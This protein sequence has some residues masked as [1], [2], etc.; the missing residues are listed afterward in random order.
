MIGIYVRL[1]RE[2][3]KIG[4]SESIDN[5]INFLK[6]YVKKQ[7]WTIYKI[8]IDDGY[9]GTNFDR[10]GFKNLI[11]DIE[12]NKIDTVITKD[13]S[14]LG[15]DYIDTGYYI[16]KY[17][18]MKKIRY[19]AVNDGI[20][21]ID[22]MN[23]N[24]DITPF[25]A[26]INDMYAKDISKKVKTALLTKA[27]NGENI[28]SFVP[29]GYKKTENNKIVIDERV[30]E[31]V[32]TIFKLYLAGKNKKEICKYLDM[33]PII[34][35]ARYKMQY[36][37]YK[38]PN[39][40][41]EGWSKTTITNILKDRTYTGDLVQHKYSSV[42]YKIK[43]VVKL[44][45]NQF[46]VIKDNHEPII[47]REEYEK[48]QQMLKDKANECKRREQNIHILTGICFCAKCGERITYTKNHGD[49]YKI[50]CSNYKKNGA[51]ACE[52]I[53]L[54]EEMV[55]SIIKNKLIENIA[56]RGLELIEVKKDDKDKII[57]LQKE[58]ERNK[59][60]I[61]QVYDD[62]KEMLISD[63]VSKELLKKYMEENNIKLEKLSKLQINEN[64][65]VDVIK[66]I[67]EAN[68]EE[69]RSLILLMISKITISKKTITIYYNYS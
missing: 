39:K 46:I 19:I 16:E 33:K 62:R 18:P 35:P 1:S 13:L 20:D 38:N 24:N 49:S 4:T 10:P 65:K 68:K 37:N 52:N 22:E 26:V 41:L 60:A 63:E 56:T 59:C 28:K 58:I 66:K 6:N 23:S 2:D 25:K 43:K 5:Q 29:Y 30:S 47:T 21:T 67:N 54:E 55:I 45:P 40:K 36:S 64:I 51:K 57:K 31:N 34:T 8:Y 17:F 44:Q 7:G 15:R 12:K 9:T 61:K 32:K 3:D 27:I 11:S 14:R 50:I 53:Y 42:N 48:V 69:V